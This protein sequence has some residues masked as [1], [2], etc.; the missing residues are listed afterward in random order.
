MEAR[1]SPAV[2]EIFNISFAVFSLK[3]HVVKIEGT[4]MHYP[5]ATTCRFARPLRCP[6]IMLFSHTGQGGVNIFRVRQAENE[7]VASWEKTS[8]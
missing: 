4:V 6:A 1:T 5:I 8:V 7:T 2:W 3:V